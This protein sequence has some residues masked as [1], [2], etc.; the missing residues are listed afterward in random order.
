MFLQKLFVSIAL[1]MHN[2]DCPKDSKENKNPNIPKLSW[3]IHWIWNALN[4][5]KRGQKMVQAISQRHLDQEIFQEFR[6]FRSEFFRISNKKIDGCRI[7]WDQKDWKITKEILSVPSISSFPFRIFQKSRRHQNSYRIFEE[8][9]IPD[10]FRKNSGWKSSWL[11]LLCNCTL[12]AF[13]AS[14]SF[15]IEAIFSSNFQDLNLRLRIQTKDL[16]QLYNKHGNS[17]FSA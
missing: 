10:E 9:L 7:L 11:C 2:L 13:E 8:F 16:Y 14:M 4:N 1:Y 5:S 6:E 15:F 3:G 17:S 12:L